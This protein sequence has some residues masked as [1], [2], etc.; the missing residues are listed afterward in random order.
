M[1]DRSCT[2]KNL[3]F[4][5]SVVPKFLGSGLRIFITLPLA[6]VEIP[7][8]LVA[9]VAFVPLPILYKLIALPDRVRSAV[10]NI[11]ECW[12]FQTDRIA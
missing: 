10:P 6:V 9:V 12:H 4:V 8:F 7:K 2:N 3:N 11:V 1:N 5:P